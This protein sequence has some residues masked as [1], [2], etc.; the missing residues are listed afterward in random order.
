MLTLFEAAKLN[1]GDVLRAAIINHFASSSELLRATQ[2]MDVPG[3]AY[4]YN[5]E[6]QLGG[7]A[8]RGVGQAYTASAGIVNPE[9]ERLRIAGG[10]LDVDLATLAFHGEEARSTHEL[11]KVKALSLSIGAAMINGNSVSNPLEFDGLRNRISGAQLIP[12]VDT[13]ATDG[14][15][16]LSLTKMYELID[17][18]DSATHL[19]MS[20]KMRALLSSAAHDTGVGGY[21][22]YDQDEFGR[23]VMMFDGLPI[24]VTDYDNLG[25]QIID[26]NEVGAGG[27]TA[28][29]TSIYCVNMGP[30]GV[31]GLQNGTMAVRDLGELQTQSV[32]RT[33]VEWFVGMAVLG[34]RSAS[35][36]YGISNAAVTK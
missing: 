27:A 2:F 32:M 22:S 33:R 3:G 36:L 9:T 26:F 4:V 13:G 16:P 14:G 28:T 8:F 29:A 19:I 30:G 21:I 18:V 12:A 17:A 6:G 5:M 23:R 11:M 34:G 7:I 20:K 10:D 31:V 15:D 35:R 1:S 24:L 25:N